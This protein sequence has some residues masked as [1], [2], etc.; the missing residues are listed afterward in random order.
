MERPIVNRVEE[1][2]LIQ[3]DLA[4]LL[5]PPPVDV[6]DLS[7]WLDRGILLREQP[8]RDHVKA[9]DAN[10]LGGHIVAL[11]CS[12]E[13]IL[14]DWAWML[15]TAKLNALGATALVGSMEDARAHAWRMAVTQLNLDDYRDQR[16]I[17]KGCATAG[18]PATLVAFTAHVGPVVRSL[19]FGEACSAVPLVK[20][21]RS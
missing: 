7:T 18:G 3:L 8:F 10:A 21:P 6:V 2:G 13:A 5:T 15:V 4:S 9:W 16:V 19:M 20:N 1:S 12:T 17:V 14:P 11:T